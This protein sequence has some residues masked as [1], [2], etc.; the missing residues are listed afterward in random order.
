MKSKLLLV[1]LPVLLLALP[2]CALF[3]DQGSGVNEDNDYSAYSA[4]KNGMSE[5]F[6]ELGY[7]PSQKLSEDEKDSLYKR[8]KL[9]RLERGLTDKER[10]QYFS[11]KSFMDSDNERADFLNLPNLAARDRY[12]QQRGFYNHVNKYAPSIKEAITH[13]DI[14]LGMSKDAVLESW[15]E[16]ENIEVAGNQVY[17]NERWTYVEYNST[18]EGFQK[19][20]RVIIFESGKVAGWK[21]YQ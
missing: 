16:P 2:G 12:A 10:E 15:G 8:L 4:Q 18:A 6:D 14:V 5:A 1:L 13:G 20:E 3:D 7:T 21:R 9:K 17:G 19:E 11:Y